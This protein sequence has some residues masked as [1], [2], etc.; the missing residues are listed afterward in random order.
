MADLDNY[1]S[2]PLRAAIFNRLYPGSQIHYELCSME[3]AF[4]DGW[5]SYEGKATEAIRCQIDRSDGC[6]FIAFKE[7]DTVDKGRA[8]DKTPE[9]L[10]KNETKA[11]GR[12]LTRAGIPQKMSELQSLMRWLVALDGPTAV[13]A[14]A[15]PAHVDPDTGEVRGS[16][17]P[18]G[19]DDP[20]AD[21]DTLTPE[22]EAAMAFSQ[23]EPA[24]KQRVTKLA[25]QA[26]IRNVMR[27]GTRAADLMTIIKG[28][29]EGA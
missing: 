22:Q 3:E 7:I 5:R 20:D 15:P 21:E 16:S 26:G 2:P 6:V 14:P 19:D 13:A 1:A 24:D 8:Q 23:L 17:T 4:P 12:A 25:S 11:L 18:D 29:D 10:A 27:A 9:N 28:T